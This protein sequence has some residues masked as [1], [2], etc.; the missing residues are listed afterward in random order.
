MVVDVVGHGR[1]KQAYLQVPG[2]SFTEELCLNKP[3]QT[4]QPNNKNTPVIIPF[5]FW[6]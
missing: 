2:Q 3:N 6:N 4:N 5:L 1:Q